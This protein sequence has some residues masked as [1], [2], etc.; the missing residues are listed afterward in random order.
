MGR[1]GTFLLGFLVGGATVYSSL[2]YHVVRADDGFHM[3]PKLTSTFSETYVDVRNFGFEEWNQHRSLA[4]ALA[5]SD[6]G[7]LVQG[8]AVD[9]L[10]NTMNDLFNMPET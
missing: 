8:I 4:L 6:K 10:Q 3:V 7:Y 9:A 2:H 5:Q 1:F